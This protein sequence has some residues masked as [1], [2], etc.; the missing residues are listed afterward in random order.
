MKYLIIL[1]A[2]LFQYW[3]DTDVVRGMKAHVEEITLVQN[4]GRAPGSEGEKAVA[5]Y[6]Y[7][8]LK[9]K[10]IDMLTGPDGDIFGLNTDKG[11]T[12]VSRNVMGMLQ[13]YD[14][15][16]KD[17]YIVVAARMDNIGSNVLTVD[18]VQRQ[19]IYGGANG[20]ASGLAM[21]LELARRL[22]TNAMLLRRSVLVV[23]FGS[24]TEMFAGSWYFLNRSF[25]D[26][27][28]IE[29]MID[30]DMVGTAEHGFYAY[31]CSNAD[32]NQIAS[33]LESTLQPVWPEVVSSEPFQSDNMAFYDKGIPSV[34]FTTGRYPEYKTD[35]DNA[36]ILNYR[37][38]ESEMEYI[39]NYSVSLANGPRPIF[40]PEAEVRKKQDGGM[41]VIPY[42]D[43]DR[44]PTFLGHADPRYF[45]QEW[46]YRYLRYPQDAVRDGI[47]GK[48]LV[49]FVIT[50]KGKIRDARV[51]RGVSPELDEEAL[52]VINASPDW[53]PGMVKGKKVNAEISLYIEFRLQ[54]KKR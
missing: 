6:V 4:E 39:Y 51:L 37:M 38:M 15:V 33:A 43:C 8:T 9:A 10:G 27:P 5:S 3:E 42:Y 34:L 23:S 47:Q 18:G 53:K 35:K 24:S 41:V 50:D 48:V 16:L 22:S 21:L 40:N 46:V 12:L 17:R 28:A 36:D 2:L 31:S 52:R 26:V 25:S 14:A 20:N 19:Q 13:G 32:L 49:D 29:A 7:E 30:L 44:R 1:L 45:L 11:D 54:K